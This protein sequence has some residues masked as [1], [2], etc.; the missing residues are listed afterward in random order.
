ELGRAYQ[1]VD[2]LLSFLRIPVRHELADAVRWRERASQIETYAAQE[3]GIARKWRR[4]N[5]IALELT[6]DVIVD[7]V[8][9]LH[10]GIVRHRRTDYTDGSA[11]NLTSRPH[12]NG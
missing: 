5:A 3:F 7:E 12:Q 2:E 10:R 4:R 9:L 6:E 11:R 8:E 1:A